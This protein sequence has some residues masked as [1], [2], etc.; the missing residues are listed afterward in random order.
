MKKDQNSIKM[1]KR[2]PIISAFV[3]KKGRMPNNFEIA[4]M[5]KIAKGGVGETTKNVIDNYQKSLEVC[6][7]CGHKLN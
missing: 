1:L 5:F 2:F 3:Q 4:K 7:V 6:I